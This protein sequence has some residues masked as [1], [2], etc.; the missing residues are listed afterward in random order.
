MSTESRRRLA[1]LTSALLLT[2]LVFT[3]AGSRPVSADDPDVNEAIAQQQQMESALA[4]HR[5]A[6]AALRRSAA[7]LT[8]SLAQI[9]GDL[10]SVGTQ[11]NRTARRLDRL[12]TNLK[13]ARRDLHDYEHR[14]DTLESDLKDV[15]AGIEQ[16]KVDLANR[17]ALLQDHLRA[18]YEQSQTSLLEVLLSTDSLSDATN[19][20]GFMLTLSDEDARL[21]EE[22]KLARE[23]LEIKE[24]T[25]REGRETLRDLRDATAQ[26]EAELDAQQE[27]V[28][29]AKR[30]LDAKR[31]ELRHLKRAQERQLARTADNAKQQRRLVR[32]Y[33]EALDAQRALVR[34]LKKQ[35]AKLDIAFHG[36][37]AWPERGHVVVT[38][39][40][41]PTRFKLEPPYTYEGVYYRHFHT[42]LD[43]AS[44]CGSPIYA[45][46]DGVVLAD[47]HPAAPGDTAI[48]VVV[49]HS[50]R[51]QSW[52][53]HMSREI[54]SVGQKVKAGQLL[55]YEGATGMATGCH[56]HLQVMF[57]DG[58]V[59]P[60]DYLP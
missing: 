7:V 60:R 59:N 9:S 13:Q 51:L 31:A 24:Q 56:L 33:Q 36:R 47:G 18:A 19:H 14:I 8:S 23:R 26:R 6:L 46:A 11:I 40:F 20:L 12:T 35:A 38:Q 45:V 50:Q 22:I 5:A 49:G 42:G 29:A 25:L 2:A 10:D 52:Y 37:F 3:G 27:Q 28:A 53:W 21:A 16:S 58:A 15:A 34:R 17:Q 48:G 30:L 1:T 57:D 54:V 39:E 32:R 44:G 41:G 4:A 43:M 55:G